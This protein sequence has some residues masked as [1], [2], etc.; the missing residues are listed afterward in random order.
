MEDT[1]QGRPTVDGSPEIGAGGPEIGT[2]G[3]R[4]G[5]GRPWLCKLDLTR[6]ES[7]LACLPKGLHRYNPALGLPTR[8]P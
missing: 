5:T 7:A 8:A 3:L 4:I 2:G 1:S 6:R